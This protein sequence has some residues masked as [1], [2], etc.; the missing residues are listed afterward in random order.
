MHY[1]S[2]WYRFCDSIISLAIATFKRLWVILVLRSFMKN[3]P[4]ASYSAVTFQLLHIYGG[5]Y[6]SVVQSLVLHLL[7]VS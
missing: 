6:T 2:Q 3:W 4:P 5:C 7:S 1:K